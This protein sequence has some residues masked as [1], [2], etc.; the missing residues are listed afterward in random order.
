MSI[1]RN[2]FSA[3]DDPQSDDATNVEIVDRLVERLETGSSIEDR[4][5]ALKALRS[6]SR[7]LRL[8][9]ATRGM[10]VYMDILEKEANLQDLVALTLDI[11]NMVL[12]DSV[13]E[14]DQEATTVAEQ[15]DEIGDRLAEV[16]LQKPTFMVSLIKL[17]E[18]YDFAVRRNAVKLLT[19]LLRHRPSAVQQAVISQAIGISHI[20]DLL[21]DKREVIRNN[22]VLMLSE[23]SRGNTAI[24][25]L[26][27]Y[28]NAFQLLFDFIAQEPL[29]S[30]V[31][32]DCLFVI[33]NLLKKNP[34]NQE[35][36]REA[37]LTKQL[38]HLANSFI[39]PAEEVDPSFGAS[40]GLPDD[41][42][43]SQKIAN[44][45]LILQCIRS[46][47]SPVDN[48]HQ[49]TH[50]AQKSLLQAGMLDLL[51]KVLLSQL[52]VSVEV[53]AE[54]VITV[55]EMIRGNYANQ[56]FFAQSTVAD[57]DGVRPALLILLLSMTSERQPFRLRLAVFYCFLCYFYDNEKGKVKIIDT[58]LPQSDNRSSEEE[59]N[60]MIGHYL[61][62]ALVNHEP[63]Q[64]WFGSVALLH[65]LLEADHLKPQ[66]LRVQ[67]ST[68]GSQEPQSLLAHL[69]RM[70]CG[71][72]PRKLQIR[73][74]LLMLL[75][76][77][78][79]NCTPAIELFLTSF[80]SN[81][82]NDEHNIVH[83]LIGQLVD[84]N[85][86]ITEAENQLVKGL[87]AF[88]VGV[89]LHCWEVAEGKADKK[90]QLTHLIERR[91]G[92]ER[93]AEYIEGISKSEFYIRAAQRP[94]PLAKGPSDLLLDYQFAKLFK[95][96]EGPLLKF[97]RPNGELSSSVNAQ[98]EGALVP[99]KKL[100]KKQDETI[101]ELT[102]EL[103]EFKVIQKLQKTDKEQLQN[104]TNCNGF[105]N[106]VA[107]ENFVPPT[108]LATSS[109]YE[110]ELSRLRTELADKMTLSEQRADAETKLQ[111]LTI[112][113]Q[114]WQAEAERYK[115][116][117]L[118]WQSYQISQLPNP[119]DSV[120]QQLEQQKIDLEQQIQYGWQAF[121]AQSTQLAELVRISEANANKAQQAERAL[122]ESNSERE[123]L[124]FHEQ[125]LQNV[126][127][128]SA[129]ATHREELALLKREHE[130][131]LLLLAEQDKK[132]H[133]YRR[134]LASHGETLSDADEEP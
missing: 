27:A 115:Q 92:R 43:S 7:N 11:M 32:E 59:S 31:V 78:T 58:L 107:H 101:A 63:V 37:N 53:L 84:Q 64:V 86:E 113:A 39:F 66:L 118:Q 42:W 120:I 125:Q 134:R 74:G 23:L 8:H 111:Q 56:E 82:G 17:L 128:E 91:V 22:V 29:D 85:T 40:G 130:D 103:K 36:F 28:E 54:S 77:W 69:G 110:E 19:S 62:G 41:E 99:Y 13:N 6:L 3:T 119:L 133:D 34:S 126:P 61:C 2:F 108:A 112:I 94:Q 102:R 15:E 96:M 44:F 131:L 49:S 57:Q 97:F 122:A 10:N 81:S 95:I 124:R 106:G 55:A 5:D 35:G 93:M 121:E 33:L 50:S 45:M 51:C 73:C 26:L 20:V 1:F 123:T 76:V 25:Q 47:V 75:S 90:T 12:N 67:L 60:A 109:A 68:A 80:G 46:L 30:I 18:C 9:V 72:G 88:L 65:T 4:R 87:V 116:W 100:I 114:Q 21:H 48:I 71:C 127:S 89:S 98:L 38:T 132:M 129:D 52:G 16:L 105:L 70:L 104:H 24:Q 117:A 79:H 14:G 83:Y